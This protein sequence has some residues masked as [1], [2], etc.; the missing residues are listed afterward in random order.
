MLY[1]F[2]W[3][4]R[5]SMLA[6]C[7]VYTYVWHLIFSRAHTNIHNFCVFVTSVEKQKNTFVEFRFSYIFKIIFQIFFSLDFIEFSRFRIYNGE[8]NW[9]LF[10]INFPLIR[11][12]EK[13][14]FFFSL[15]SATDVFESM[16]ELIHLYLSHSMCSI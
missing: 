4:F 8:L 3:R 9:S 5:V 2:E 12:S 11:Y 13:I 10:T 6:L 15:Q 16:Y 1:N 14:S 7:T